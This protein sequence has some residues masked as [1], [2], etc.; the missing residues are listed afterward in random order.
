ME[1]SQ[2]EIVDIEALKAP[3]P[4]TSFSED[5]NIICT[6]TNRLVN[7]FYPCYS[8]DRDTTLKCAM[9]SNS[10]AVLN[11]ITFYR[12]A[13]CTIDNVEDLM[14]YF[15]D[16]MQ[17][18]L[19]TI[20]SINAIV[21][22][23][24]VGYKGKNSLV[25]GVKSVN[26]DNVTKKIIEGLLPGMK[27]NNF[28]GSFENSPN[29]NDKYLGIINGTPAHKIDGQ[30]LKKNLSTIMKSLNGE[31]YTLLI[32]SKP[33]SQNDIQNRIGTAI[34]IRDRCAAI[35]KRNVI[36]QYSESNSETETHGNSNTNSTSNTQGKGTS[37]TNGFNVNLGIP[38][39]LI[40]AKMGTIAGSGIPIAGNIIGAVG[41]GIVGLIVGMQLNSNHSKTHSKNT[42]N[43]TGKAITE[44][45]SKA[46]S[47][48]ITNG[49]SVALDIQN[50]YALEL[51][52]LAENAKDRLKIGSNIGLWETTISYSAD[53]S[54]A[55][56]IIQGCMY[57]EIA[58]AQKEVLPPSCIAT[59]SSELSMV[60]GENNVQGIQHLIIPKG[61]FETSDY[62]NSPLSSFINTEELS[63][64]CTIPIEN[65]PGFE[66]K[67]SKSYPLVSS[68]AT[69]S[70]TVQL[71][72]V[73]EYERELENLQFMLSA[74]E[75]NKHTF[76]CGITGSGKTNTVKHILRNSNKPFLVIE[77]V[78]KEYRN[79]EV[80]GVAPTVYT[81]GKP[82]LNSLRINPF[83][84][85]PGVSPQQHI[86][87]L[88]D[89]FNASFSFYGPMPYIVE[90]CLHNIYIK[91]GWNLTLGY[92]PYLVNRKS[93]S[94]FFNSDKIMAQYE[95]DA[96]RYLF[97]TMQDLKDEVDHYIQYEMEYDGEIRGNIK[98]AIKARIDSLCVGA[99]GYM[100]NTY[101]TV[102]FEKILNTNCVMEL[103]GLADDADKAFALGLLIIVITEHRQI[104][105]EI[106]NENKLELKHLLVIE[107][108]HRLLKN[109]AT[110][111]NS[112]TLGNPKGKAVEHFTNMVAEMRSYGQ[113]VIVA[114]QIPSKLSPDVIKNSSNKIIHR[115]IAKDDQELIAN[116]IGISSEDAIYIGN[117]LT[118]YAL[119]HKEGMNLPVQ[120]KIPEVGKGNISDEVLYRENL[121][122]KVLRI[123][124]SI[125]SSS[126]PK[127]ITAIA[128]KLFNS[129]LL[130]SDELILSA[131]I[132]VMGKEIK[133]KLRQ[134]HT[135]II[136]VVDFDETIVSLLTDEIIAVM[137]NGA[138]GKNVL[139]DNIFR[140]EIQHV[141]RQSRVQ[142]F[143]NLKKKLEE[144]FKKSSSDVVEDL[145][146]EMVLEAFIKGENVEQSVNS[147]L[148]KPDNNVYERV[149]KKLYQRRCEYGDY[150]NS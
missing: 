43:T 90:K 15:T 47:K 89:L 41:G 11:T 97:P 98:S 126:I 36:R 100:F 60:K 143:E 138:Y 76:V 27:L 18:L 109:I 42:S 66:I 46:I 82:E 5:V 17:K 4:M 121:E 140:E 94:E 25:I 44:S 85:L 102:D 68:I 132:E 70:N 9:E 141:L 115:V 145:I 144:L 32:M 1:N 54:I 123:N 52:Q 135:S 34:D 106:S 33:V 31:N 134:A 19:M 149:L 16:K 122:A 63:G 8:Y 130:Y 80:N 150:G 91:K 147:Y 69:E 125:I 65:V 2:N 108:A 58:S 12:I 48:S 81:L 49:G 137:T 136:P 92:H 21:C 6:E 7:Q 22:Y 139:V 83:Y 45:Y 128:V 105:K 40:G 124:K 87:F 127:D 114:E 26:D 50:G 103:E 95:K 72:N 142:S 86:D 23:G 118:G 101:E 99:K 129:I 74:S 148:V 112:E 120:V 117:S 116:M 56:D 10:L 51:M 71:G 13:E 75:L 111:R 113:G 14:E 28:S 133:Q 59:T 67:K 119:C 24:I 29:L 88:K 55:R 131:C 53:S 110:E 61:F 3:D 78:K 35:S 93:L 37:R 30:A 39:M 96:H 107:E 84:I 20:Y 62:I 73:C 146:V 79:I 104:F 77:P 38:G 64:V 57:S